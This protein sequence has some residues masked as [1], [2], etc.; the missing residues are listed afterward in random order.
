MIEHRLRRRA[1]PSSWRAA[2][3]LLLLP[4]AALAQTRRTDAAGCGAVEV[5]NEGQHAAV[6]EVF[7]SPLDV[8]VVDSAGNPASSVRVF[9][10]VV[11]GRA[12][13]ESATGGDVT[14]D[15]Q[16][17]S[18]LTDADGRTSVAMAAGSTPGEVLVSVKAVGDSQAPSP[19]GIV[20][21]SVRLIVDPPSWPEGVIPNTGTTNTQLLGLAALV[22]SLGVCLLLA[23]N[24]SRRH[25]A[26][27]IGT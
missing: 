15:G 17:A 26:S 24:R 7:A 13:I 19:V 6:N 22:S 18:V 20:S 16:T 4:L 5:T 25:D 8:T 12:S 10:M 23:R 21:T 2:A 9:L 11:T 3:A 27:S 1:S 14:P